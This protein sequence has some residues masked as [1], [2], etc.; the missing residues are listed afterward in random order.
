VPKEATVAENPALV[1]LAGTFTV[2]GTETTP[3]LLDR[4]TLSPPLGAAALRVTVQASVPATVMVPLLQLSELSAAALAVPV[5]LR[6]ITAEGPVEELLVMVNCPVAAP[7]DEGSNCKVSAAAWLGFNV[8]GNEAPDIVK[9]VPVSEA[10]LM[11]TGAV[12]VDVSVSDCFEAVLTATL[13]KLTLPALTLRVGIVGAV[14]FNCSE[15]LLELLFADAV[16]CTDCAEVTADTV[17]LKLAV[18]ALAGTVT[19]AGTVTAPLSLLR[20]TLCPPLPA[21]PLIVTVQASVPAPV[22]DP[23]LQENPLTLI[24]WFAADFFPTPCSFT[25]A[26][27]LVVELLAMVTCPVDVAS[28]LGLKCTLKLIVFPAARVTGSAP[29]PSTENAVPDKVN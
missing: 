5:P 11:V 6:P 28:E 16:N 26:V 21:A 22:M 19:V 8:T 13:P 1:A 18:V 9:P 24:D 7:A 10:A 20:L 23:V 2:A 15:K 3:S 14:A 4:V 27:G 12:P 25:A 29:C 17:A